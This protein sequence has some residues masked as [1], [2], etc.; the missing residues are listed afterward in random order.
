MTKLNNCDILNTIEAHLS[1][2]SFCVKPAQAL[3]KRKDWVPKRIFCAKIS[4]ATR[5]ISVLLS[6]FWSECYLIFSHP[7]STY[8]PLKGRRRRRRCTSLP[9]FFEYFSE[10]LR[11]NYFLLIVK[12]SF[13]RANFALM[14]KFINNDL[15]RQWRWIGDK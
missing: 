13:S 4:L 10:G 3:Q 8:Q 2:S 14:V 15:Y 11:E 1:I 9:Y 12:L 7:Y 6:T 5:R